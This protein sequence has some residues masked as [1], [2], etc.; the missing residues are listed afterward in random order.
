[1][2]SLIDRMFEFTDLTSRTDILPD[3]P[4]VRY[5]SLKPSEERPR[6]RIG[7]V[8]LDI[9]FSG[10][11]RYI[12]A[13]L[14]GL[15]RKE[16][17]VI[18][19]CRREPHYRDLDDVRIV[20]VADGTATEQDGATSVGRSS[21]PARLPRATVRWL[22]RRLAP[23]SVKHFVGFLR[24]AKRLAKFVQAESVDI[25]HVQVVGDAEG[26]LAGRLARV[27]R[28][29]GTYHMN[30][31]EDR[32]HRWLPEILT[33]RC[34]A[35]AIFVSE[36]TKD[37]WCRRRR[38]DAGRVSVI[39]NGESAKELE[40]YCLASGVSE[41]FRFL[42]WREDLLKI[43]ANSDCAIL[44]S[45]CSE[46]LSVAILESLTLGTPAIVTSVGGMAEAVRHGETG[47]VV[48]PRCPEALC[49]AMLRMIADR[50]WTKRLGAEARRD[51]TRRFSR[52]RMLQEYAC[53]FQE[54]SASSKRGPKLRS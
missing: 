47:L 17:E 4:S 29:V 45:I 9:G 18:L 15:D 50:D 37:Q 21:V 1:L 2:L 53:V 10:I 7:I 26:A 48:A 30:T 33:T 13:L 31:R 42:G 22:W 38:F 6:Y 52:S 11:T 34:L 16:F 46:N 5:R 51:A 32:K 44:P 27:P 23:R 35:N 49:T 19:F 36:S 14:R 8:D 41:I 12:L 39:P 40:E 43:L 54:F 20:Y 3:V 24:D 25:L 28:I